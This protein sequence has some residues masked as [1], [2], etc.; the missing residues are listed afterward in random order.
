MRWQF[1]PTVLFKGVVLAAYLAVAAV[2]SGFTFNLLP[3]GHVGGRRDRW[4]GR[5][6]KINAPVHE[7]LRNFTDAGGGLNPSVY[8]S[9]FTCTIKDN[10]VTDFCCKTTFH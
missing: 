1:P 3:V 6:R 10:T 7:K 9:D 2:E 5:G 4:E 8:C